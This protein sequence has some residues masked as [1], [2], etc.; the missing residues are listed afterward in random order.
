MINFNQLIVFLNFNTSIYII[1]SSINL[2][3][4]KIYIKIIKYDVWIGIYN[5]GLLLLNKTSKVYLLAQEYNVRHYGV[6]I[7]NILTYFSCLLFFLSISVFILSFLFLF[8]PV[9]RSLRF[10]SL[11]LSS[12]LLVPFASSDLYIHSI[13]LSETTSSS[14]RTNA[15]NCS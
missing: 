2:F 7:I 14:C 5:D 13:S 1:D 11:S 15:C 4:T 9:F 3:I 12:V 6:L 10:T 8:F